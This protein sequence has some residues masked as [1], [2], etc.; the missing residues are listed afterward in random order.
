LFGTILSVLLIPCVPLWAAPAGVTFDQSALEVVCY[1]FVEVTLRVDKPDVSNP[2][3]DGSVEGQ[4]MLSG[5]QAVSVDGFCDSA[6]GSLFCI[7]FMPTKAGDYGYS[8]TYRQGTYEVAHKGKFTARKGNRPGLLRV[9]RKCPFHFIYE[10]TGEHFF[11]NST[12][13]YWL[14]GWRDDAVIE[15]SLDRLAKLGVNRIRVALS[16]RTRDGMRWKEADVKP[17]EKFQFRLEP[18]PAA[19]PDNIEDPGYDVT[20]FNLDH[21]HRCERMLEHA[22]KR[23]IQVSII[24]HLDGADKGVDPFGKAGMGGPDEQRYYRY[25]VARLAVFPNVMWDVTNEWH[26]FREEAWVEKMGRLIKGCDPYDHLTSVH[27]KGEFPFRTSPWADYAMYQ[28]WDEHGGYA[29]ML[30]NRQEQE[31]AGRPMPQI[32]EEYGYEDHYPYPWG[33]GRKS[34]A[35]AADNRRRL[36]WQMTMAGGYQTTGERANVPG[37]GGWITGRGDDTMVMLEDYRHM[38]DFFTSLAWWE[39]KPDNDFFEAQGGGD[40]AASDGAIPP[41]LGMRSDDKALAVLYFRRG[42]SARIKSG[43]LRGDLQPAWFNP[44]A[45]VWLLAYPDEHGRFVPP[46]TEDWALQFGTREP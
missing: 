46:D 13:T 1:N 16:G 3:T 6:D 44:R 37:C 18:W 21:F 8:V 12:T 39:L 31:K 14:L 32:N 38:V 7:R 19:R 26:L 36:A 20:R 11:W 35:R 45:N 22:R 43:S 2:F 9:D 29:F 33:E 24:F 4:F 25:V 27:G 23:R 30:K 17:S 42:G 28:S 41:V 34:P 40:A 5:A 10:G 15:E